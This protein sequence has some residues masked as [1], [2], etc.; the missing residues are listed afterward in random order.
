MRVLRQ[1]LDAV[2]AADVCVLATVVAV[3]GSAPRRDAARLLL[4]ASGVRTGT[5][6]GG[7]VEARTLTVAEAMFTGPDAAQVIEVPVNCGGT[8]TVML[9]KFAPP[10]QLLVIGAGHVGTAVARAGTHAGYRVTLASP[11]HAERVHDL[12]GVEPLATADPAVLAGWE[13]PERTHVV[14]AT[15]DAA[16]DGAWA[17]AALARSFAGVGVV[18]SRNKAEAIRHAAAAAGI[19][20]ARMT[21]LRCPVGLDLGAVTPEEIAVAIVA[22]LIRLD[23]TGEVPEGWRRVSRG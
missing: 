9:E 13:H 19:G 12:A 8:V 10:R 1:L 4:T 7:E 14:V 21:A 20:A 6:G 18:G 22:E 23:R 17:L 3:R 5:V 11:A 2:D 16:A 15:G